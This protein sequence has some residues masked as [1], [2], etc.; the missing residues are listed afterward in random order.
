MKTPN[1]SIPYADRY[2]DLH[3]HLDGS[4]T[5][6]IARRLAAL[7][8]IRLPAENGRE[9]ERLLTVSEDCT[10]LNDFLKCLALP[11]SLMQTYEGLREGAYLVAESMKAQGVIYGEIRY[12]PQLHTDRGM[13]QEDAVRAVLE[14]LE[15][16]GGHINT[17]LCCMRGR[18]LEEK[19]LETVELAR[20]YLVE[21]G[22]VVALDLAGAEALYPTSD[23]RELFV[24]AGEYGIPLTIHAGEA[25]GAE[26]VR[27]AIEYGAV[28]IG[29]GVRSYEDESVLQ[30]IR[31]KGIFLEMCPT[32]NRQTQ[33]VTDMT[34]YP[35]MDYLNTGIR[36]T[37]NSDDPGVE[38]TTIGKEYRY[39]EECFGL[40]PLQEKLLLSNAVDAAFTSSAVKSQLRRTLGL[41]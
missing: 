14:G 38:G 15:R 25:A 29:H 5:S 4:V 35:F 3:T 26:N 37:L 27:G 7:Q 20:K 12:A 30:L 23:F 17:I 31:D 8:G 13:T 32:S 16:S 22:G 1:E 39:M 34:K 28:R 18:G 33:A 40:T 24:K 9:L 11:V 10:S 41:I 2:I 19:N 6:D 36:V 21:D